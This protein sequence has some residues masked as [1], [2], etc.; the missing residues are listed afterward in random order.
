MSG[1][2][3]FPTRPTFREPLILEPATVVLKA[4]GITTPA[5]SPS[6]SPGSEFD[7]QPKRGVMNGDSICTDDDALY[8]A[9]LA[10]RLA[11]SCW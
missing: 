1:S 3:V 9:A 6:A 2:T 8:P 10:V 11:A 4:K 5:S 7:N